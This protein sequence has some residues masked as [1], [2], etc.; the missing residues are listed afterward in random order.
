MKKIVFYLFPVLLNALLIC[1][2]AFAKDLQPS[3]LFGEQYNPGKRSFQSTEEKDVDL[4]ISFHHA[5]SKYPGKRNLVSRDMIRLRSDSE[6]ELLY[7]HACENSS[8]PNIIA[9]FKMAFQEFAYFKKFK[10]FLDGFEE[11]VEDYSRKYKL[12]GE[13]GIDDHAPPGTSGSTVQNTEKK[14]RTTSES[15]KSFM[16]STPQKISWQLSFD[17]D[18]NYL[19][20]ELAIGNHFLI[21]GNYGSHSDVKAVVTFPF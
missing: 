6:M 21:E 19:K 12:K 13:V 9:V 5:G 1:G 17:L 16:N 20:G 2:P 8:S 15:V 7:N 4:A 11:K 10:E 18:S 3:F 14:S